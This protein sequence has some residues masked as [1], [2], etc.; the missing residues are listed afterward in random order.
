MDSLFMHPKNPSVNIYTHTRPG[1]TIMDSM[2]LVWFGLL[3]L[4]GVAAAF[5][6][7]R[8]LENEL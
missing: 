8:D 5:M 7:S 3:I 1:N 2:F 4:I 6:N